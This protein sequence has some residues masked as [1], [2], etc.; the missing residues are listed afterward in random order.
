MLEVATTL[1]QK[2]GIGI[3]HLEYPHSVVTD[4]MGEEALV[5]KVFSS[6][7]AEDAALENMGYRPGTSSSL[8]FLSLHGLFSTHSRHLINC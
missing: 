2:C 7:V 8:H 1:S 5:G 3:L 6:G 4:K